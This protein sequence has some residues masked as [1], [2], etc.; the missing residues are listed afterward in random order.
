MTNSRIADMFDQIADLLEFQAANPFR[1]RAYRNGAR[2]IRDLPEPVTAILDDE[3]RKLTDIEGIGKDLADKVKT[4]AD[5]GELPQLTK[6]LQEVPETVLAMMRVP[7]L[8]PKKAAVL[9]KE[10]GVA[11]LEQLKAA[12]CRELLNET[13]RWVA[14]S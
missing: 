3:N 8:G 5:T 2:V 4:L 12:R 13:K 6:L 9:F 7:G 1:V 14:A 11:T 10:L